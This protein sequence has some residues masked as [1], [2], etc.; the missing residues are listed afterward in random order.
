MSAGAL[1]LDPPVTIAG[2]PFAPHHLDLEGA[3]LHYLDEGPRGADP[4]VFVHGNGDTAALWHSTIWHWESAGFPDKRLFAIDFPYP[5]ARNNDAEYQAGRSSTQDQ[6]E[7]LSQAV[8][9][10][11]KQTGERVGLEHP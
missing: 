11:L 6:M 2:Y 1:A 8:Q 9:Q 7:Q 5:L 3:R 4:I 10:A